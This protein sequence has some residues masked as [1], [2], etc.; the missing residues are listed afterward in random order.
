MENSFDIVKNLVRTEKGTQAEPRGKYLFEVSLKANKI[1]I[2]RAIEL[3]YKVKVK[4]VNTLVVVGK[5]RRVRQE[6]GR[7]PNW[8]KAVVTL[9]E[10]QKIE[11]T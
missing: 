8:K 4:S 11:V 9:R 10:G 7:T 1:Q 5:L 6:L 3:I 2:K